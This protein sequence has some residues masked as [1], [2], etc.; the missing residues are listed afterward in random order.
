MKM[1]LYPMLLLSLFLLVSRRD[2][3]EAGAPIL[4]GL[5]VMP[6]IIGAFFAYWVFVRHE[7]MALDI[8]IYVIAMIGAVHLVKIWRDSRFIRDWW[9][10]W[11]VVAAVLVFLTGF[12]TYNAP[13][14]CIVFADLG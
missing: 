3:R 12:L 7:I 4:G 11:M 6:L 14:D 9:P 1:V 10:L 13:A 8:A 2:I 5:A